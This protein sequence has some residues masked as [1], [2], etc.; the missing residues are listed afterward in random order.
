LLEACIGLDIEGDPV[1]SRLS[2][3]GLCNESVLKQALALGVK[4]FVAQSPLLASCR[5]EEAAT[6]AVKGLAT[7]HP[8][9]TQIERI[10]NIAR[11]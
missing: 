11:D 6:S 9:I 1:K 2:L 8:D 7:R 3:S 10:C 5:G 4:R